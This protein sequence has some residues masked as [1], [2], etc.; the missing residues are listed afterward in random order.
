MTNLSSSSHVDL[1]PALDRCPTCQHPVSAHDRIGVR[2]CAATQ[3]GVGQRE[4][5]CIVAVCTTSNTGA[6]WAQI[7]HGAAAR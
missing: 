1:D 6:S 7:R 3:L 5:M 4:C 2:W